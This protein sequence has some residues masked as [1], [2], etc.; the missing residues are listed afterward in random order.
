MRSG[1][2]LLYTLFEQ[3]L[4]NSLVEDDT[5]DALIQRVVQDYLRLLSTKGTI[6]HG[7]Q[8]ELESDLKEEVLE[9]LRKR[10]YGHYNL[11]AFRKS[12]QIKSTEES[13]QVPAKKERRSRGAS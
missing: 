1:F 7:Q 4:L 9:M 5:S 8:E 13:A 12:L 3:H 11:S 2:D 10:T 6:P